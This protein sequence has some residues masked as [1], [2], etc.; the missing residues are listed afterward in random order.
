LT[1]AG[2]AAAACI[3]VLLSPGAA[4]ACACG[5]GVFAVGTSSSF[6]TG[7]GMMA[8]FE[9][10]FMNQN[11]NWSNG[12]AAPAQNNDDKA[13]R[14]SFYT[15]GF[16]YVTA[17][18]WGVSVELPVWARTFK[19]TDEDTG[20]IV[21]FHHTDFGDVRIRGSW[22]G[23]S[24]D[25][26]TGLTFGV[27]LPTG[28]YSYP[29][30]DRDTAIGSGSTDLLLGAYHVGEIDEEGTWNWFANAE[31]DLPLITQ[32]GYRPGAELDAVAGISY[33]GWSIG[34]VKI[35]PV[36]EAIQSY[37]QRDAG[38]ASDRPSS[39]Y[40][41]LLIAP[42]VEVDA[43]NVKVYANVA[44]PVYQNVNGNQL[45]APALFKLN[46]AYMF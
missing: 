37:R 35:A 3:S 15:A 2:P 28:D 17:D 27:K 45:V 38:P 34:D 23:L 21:N 19:T 11:K 31:V 5:C 25:H 44:L 20:D 33:N 43:D 30:F 16:Q 41:R 1:V 46:V 4:M 10:D 39:G 40:D 29:G 22:S 32:D 8:Y 24:D 36:L 7:E 6:P 12:S 18:G 9:Y 13:I 14:T 42:G 26:Q